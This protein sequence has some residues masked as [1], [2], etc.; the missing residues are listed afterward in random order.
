MSS[1][2]YGYKVDLPTQSC[3]IFVTLHKSE[4]IAESIAYKDEL[5]DI[6]T[7]LW[8]TKSNRTLQS[9]EVKA[10]LN[11]SVELH[12]FS[13]KND[14]E[15]S[16]HYY[17]GRATARDAEQTTMPNSAGKELAVVRMLLNFEQPIQAG[18]FDYFHTN[19]TD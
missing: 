19:L 2:I 14:A 16:G 13:K 17:L 10:I 1:T 5:L 7:M 9:P 12:I 3:P 11:N 15:G 18:L 6:N 4:E 8:Y